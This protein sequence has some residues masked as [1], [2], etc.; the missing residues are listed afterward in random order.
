M[1]FK[2]SGIAIKVVS[3]LCNEDGRRLEAS[4]PSL[5]LLSPVA[6]EKFPFR[7][8]SQSPC[9]VQSEDPNI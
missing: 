6:R 1:K 5:T 4:G 8:M 9:D 7:L 3:N 2:A